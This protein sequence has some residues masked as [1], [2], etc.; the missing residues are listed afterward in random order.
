MAPYLRVFGAS[1]PTYPLLL[2]A[3]AWAGLW[4]SARQAKRLGLDGDHIYNMGLYALLATLVGA[5]LAYA[6]TH[7]SAYQ[8]ALLSAFSTTPAALSWPEGA[9]I[10]GVV[11]LVYWSHYRLP[12]G[13]TLDAIAPGL[14]LAMALERLGAYL[15]G[16][17]YGEPTSLP[18]GVFLWGEVRH[19][20]Q[21]YEMA[22]LLVILAVLG[23]RWNR[24]PFRGH[25]F[26][27][28]AALYAGSRLLLEAFRFGAP[29]MAGGIR[30][31][32]VVA[33]AAM[34]GAVWYLYRRRFASEPTAAEAEVKGEA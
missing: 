14:A 15:G 20:V 33:L 8:G 1:V 13:A 6:A 34:L 16:R 31:L 25:S 3:A 18:W 4:L 19:P 21:L 23:W 27:L 5:R 7:W 32:Q 28:F 22:A 2:L 24:G 12:V 17:N 11:A 26:V 10:G 9:L 30:T 29:L